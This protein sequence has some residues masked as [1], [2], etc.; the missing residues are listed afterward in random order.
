MRV[1]LTA[2]GAGKCVVMVPRVCFSCKAKQSH[3][4]HTGCQHSRTKR[5]DNRHS[6]NMQLLLH[7]RLVFPCA[8]PMCSALS[9]STAAGGREPRQ[10]H[11][12][13]SP[14]VVLCKCI[15]V[16]LRGLQGS[17][18]LLTSCLL[19]LQGM[20]HQLLVPLLWGEATEGLLVVLTAGDLV[21]AAV[22]QLPQPQS[23]SALV[24]R[25]LRERAE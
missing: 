19:L 7:N 11:E 6:W 16:C 8:V 5:P 3:Q 23:L 18:A 21:H 9:M 10:W 2:D 1:G 12:P 13:T 22:L 25:E 15:K 14:P 4:D 20:R 24:R 17:K